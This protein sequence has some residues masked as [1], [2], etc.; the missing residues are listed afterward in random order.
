L[1][2]APSVIV[3]WS[4]PLNGQFEWLLR[5]PGAA[6]KS[7]EGIAYVELPMIPSLG[8]TKM[9]VCQLDDR[10]LFAAQSAALFLSRLSALQGPH[11][12]KTWEKAWRD[13]DGGLLA[14]VSTD[15]NFARPLADPVDGEAKLYQDLFSHSRLHAVGVD[16]QEGAEGVTVVKAQF[17]FD[18]AED[19]H[20]W[21]NA[22]RTGTDRAV[23]LV[24][25]DDA[26]GEK[27]KTEK[28]E[29]AEKQIKAML[30]A[31][32]QAKIETYQ[33]DDGWV[34]DVQIAGPFDYRP[35][36]GP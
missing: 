25:A 6:E 36:W 17:G 12:S 21:K 35:L 28:G 24:K 9:C 15:A 13:V 2:G 33:S 18:T 32:Q 27:E 20:R 7:H 31:L 4:K 1:F 26:K 29:Q 30:D 16:W 19:A 5:T 8:P 10:T 14:F 3:R 34:V 11:E 23:D 22:I